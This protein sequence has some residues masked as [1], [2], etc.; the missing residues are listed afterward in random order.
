MDIDTTIATI[1][2]YDMHYKDKNN[3]I[4]YIDEDAKENAR[5]YFIRWLTVLKCNTFKIISNMYSCSIEFYIYSRECTNSKEYIIVCEIQFGK[6]VSRSSYKLVDEIKEI[7][8]ENI[9]DIISLII[10]ISSND[11]P[12]FIGSS[13]IDL[14]NLQM[15]RIATKIE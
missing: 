14:I 4:Y 11:I 7:D 8:I 15:E 12:H 10:K 2:I 3:I 5:N 6:Q 13:M 1:K 9:S